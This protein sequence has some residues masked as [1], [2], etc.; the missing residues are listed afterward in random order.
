MS[1]LTGDI[2][3]LDVLQSAALPE[4]S[5]TAA[6]VPS[7]VQYTLGRALPVTHVRGLLD[8]E[9]VRAL[10]AALPLELSD[11]TPDEKYRDASRLLFKDRHNLQV[12]LAARLFGAVTT[13]APTY[14]FGFVSFSEHGSTLSLNPCFRVSLYPAGSS[15]FQWH[16]DAPFTGETTMSSHSVLVCLENSGGGDTLFAVER[17]AEFRTLPETTSGLT[18]AEEMADWCGMDVVRLKLLPGDVV[19]FDQRLMHCAEALHG[20]TKTIMRTDVLHEREPTSPTAEGC[21]ALDVARQL[22]RVAEMGEV[23]L[24][25]V[26]G[27]AYDRKAVTDAVRECYERSLHIRLHPSRPLCETVHN[28]LLRGR[29]LLRFAA[30]VP[31]QTDRPV[32]LTSEAATEHCPEFALQVMEQ[33]GVSWTFRHT[34]S[35]TSVPVIASLVRTAALFAVV[36]MTKVLAGCTV[37]DVLRLVEQVEGVLRDRD[38]VFETEPLPLACRKSHSKSLAAAMR[39]TGPCEVWLPDFQWGNGFPVR[40]MAEGDVVEVPS[41]KH[42]CYPCRKE[43]DPMPARRVDHASVRQHVEI[44]R[45]PIVTRVA[46]DELLPDY[47]KG[48]VCF[49]LPGS[50]EEP[51]NH[52]GCHCGSYSF[53]ESTPNRGAPD[54]VGPTK[55]VFN[56]VVDFEFF[57]ETLTVQPHLEVVM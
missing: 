37:V 33:D 18:V 2:R 51:Y 38:E 11:V 8:P 5:A 14:K 45:G 24:N 49:E 22:F 4:L 56:C 21:P 32:V 52:A 35:E 34:A 19:V 26:G 27:H 20:G 15:G 36:A 13:V 57:G 53:N 39:S 44:K 55:S 28:A 25:F 6:H 48:S 17:D 29:A 23:I 40:L 41:L 47:S 50:G 42:L 16:R 43:G 12:N 54:D 31:L 9:E 30:S 46:F 1:S 3:G 7:V 10:L